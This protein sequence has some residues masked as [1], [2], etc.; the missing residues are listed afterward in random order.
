MI[1]I[2]NIPD[3]CGQHQNTEHKSADGVNDD[4]GGFE[5]DNNSR[6]EDT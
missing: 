2:K 6:S 5:V 4:P 1:F 3:S